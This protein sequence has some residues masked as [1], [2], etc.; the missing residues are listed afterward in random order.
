MFR[1]LWCFC[2]KIEKYFD[3][4]WAGLGIK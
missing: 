3:K 2:F 1:C 4:V